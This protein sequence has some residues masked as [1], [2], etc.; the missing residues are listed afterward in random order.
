MARIKILDSKFFGISRKQLKV[1]IYQYVKQNN[2]D[3]PFNK[4][5]EM[6]GDKWIKNFC[7]RHS[8]TLRQPEKCSLGRA[9]GF[10]RI[11]FQ[12]FHDNLKQIFDENPGLCASDIYNMDETSVSTVPNKLPKVIAP[13][14]KQL[15]SKVVS[16]ER[17]ESVTGVCC[18]SAAGYYVPPAL[19]FPRKKF[20][21]EFCDRAPPDTLGMVS[22][23]GFINSELFMTWLEHFRK[24]VKPSQQTKKLLILDN[25]ISHCSLSAI[26]YCQ[27]KGIILLSLPPHASH[28]LQPLDVTFFGPLKKFLSEEC[29]RWITQHPGRPITIYQVGEIFGT[30]YSKTASVEKAIKS[31]KC[32][33][34]FPQNPEAFG[35]ED[36]MPSSVTERELEKPPE[37]VDLGHDAGPSFSEP[38]EII[39]DPTEVEEH[40]QPAPTVSPKDLLPSPKGHRGKNKGNRSKSSA[41][42]TSTPFKRS[43]EDA[44]KA[45]NQRPKRKAVKK[46]AFPVQDDDDDVLGILEDDDDDTACIYCNGLYTHSKHGE[47]WIQCQ[48]CRLWAHTE[49]GGIDSR[50]KSYVCE[51]C[52]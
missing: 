50:A 19:I 23:S 18:V 45:V 52:K 48:V 11:Q 31:F 36:F 27:E 41:I 7:Q 35:D 3:H 4:K 44:K 38:I 12:K 21:Q 2:L 30:A 20:K 49:C 40:N 16:Q 5:T 46:L 25:H 37:N 26:E 32:T 29:D 14:G 8:L 6:A 28:K 33:G 1:V 17:G 43:L 15:V 22:D 13:K 51:L 10:N 34:I 9:I 42:M 24:H 47:K 39:D